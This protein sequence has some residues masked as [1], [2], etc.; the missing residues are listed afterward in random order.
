MKILF[1][2][3]MSP[4]GHKNYNYGILRPLCESNDVELLIRKN[5]LNT[6]EQ[7]IK[8][9]KTHFIPD[10]YIP[11]LMKKN[12]KNIN[13]F[14]FMYRLQQYRL[15]K[16]IYRN[17]EIESFDVVLFSSVDIISFSLAMKQN[18]TRVLFV[19]HGISDIG[20][21]RV[22]KFFWNRLD[23]A[24]ELIVLEP[25]IKKYMEEKV[26]IKNKIWVVPHPLPSIE[27]EKYRKNNSNNKKLIFAPGLGNDE[28]FINYLI[29]NYQNIPE[30]YEI[31]IR[32][33]KQSVKCGNLTVYEKRIDDDEYYGNF[34]KS[35]YV[36]LPY[37]DHYNYKTSGV[38]FEAVYIKK[39]ILL[40]N[41]NTLKYYNKMFPGIITTFD[42]YDDFFQLINQYDR[43]EGINEDVFEESL[44]YYSY[45]SIR[46]K[47]NRILENN[48]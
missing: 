42:K 22:K 32:S 18:R 19:D 41:N 46:E 27:F 37:T 36:L 33:R 26:R 20:K 9:K 48:N 12:Y 34:L 17:F 25:Y 47:L 40:R 45:I 39:P 24:L 28:G 15:V 44:E 6:K 5:F 31:I 43:T 14:K 35:E 10:K 4:L 16:W 2:D 8:V 11:E 7:G 29:T 23:L 21:S 1:V 30:N 13:A 38:F 3:L